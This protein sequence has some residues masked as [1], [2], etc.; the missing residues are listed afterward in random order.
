MAEDRV[1]FQQLVRWLG[2]ARCNCQ[3]LD[4][5]GFKLVC[6]SRRGQHQ[7]RQNASSVL[8][9]RVVLSCRRRR[10]VVVVSGGSSKR[11]L[12]LRPRSFG[13]VGVVVQ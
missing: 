1:L 2:V 13:D 12:R 7:L 8:C 4:P 3:S 5:E 10:V 6:S 9:F 11:V